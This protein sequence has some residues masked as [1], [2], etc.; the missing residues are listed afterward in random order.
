MQI[1]PVGIF[2]CTGVFC[3][4]T[5]ILN[6]YVKNDSCGEQLY[7]NINFRHH[8]YIYFFLLLYFFF[9]WEVYV[10]CKCVVVALHSKIF[11]VSIECIYGVWVQA[12]PLYSFFIKLNDIGQFLD[13]LIFCCCATRCCVCLALKNLLP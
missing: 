8:I 5:S 13:A 2:L 9:R 4:Q 6:W 12:P 3:S 11:F 1:A 7:K 10:P